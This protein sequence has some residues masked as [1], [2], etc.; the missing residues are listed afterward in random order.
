MKYKIVKKNRLFEDNA[1]E[2]KSPV[3]TPEQTAA[4]ERLEKVN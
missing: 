3:E 4:K 2:Q 1:E